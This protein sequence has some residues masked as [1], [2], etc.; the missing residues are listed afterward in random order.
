MKF[1]PVYLEAFSKLLF[2]YGPV[3]DAGEG[4]TYE[5][6]YEISCI[7]VCEEIGPYNS[8]TILKGT[9]VALR[10]MQ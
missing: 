10:E 3:T 1:E 8:S 4:M 2:M 7:C 5:G 6:E 9:I